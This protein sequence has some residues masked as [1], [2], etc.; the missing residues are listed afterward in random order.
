M[1][2]FTGGC[3]GIKTCM[4][5]HVPLKWVTEAQLHRQN[6]DEYRRSHLIFAAHLTWETSAASLSLPT[7]CSTG[8]QSTAARW[9]EL[10]LTLAGDNGSHLGSVQHGSKHSRSNYGDKDIS[11]ADVFSA[12]RSECDW[13]WLW[14]LAGR[15]QTFIVLAFFSWMQINFFHPLRWNWKIY[16]INI[17]EFIWM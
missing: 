11:L 7:P 6:K 17:R 3:C 10:T 2:T 4:Y 5:G 14:V 9:Q 8:Y 15:V 12:K 16:K 1:H 13:V